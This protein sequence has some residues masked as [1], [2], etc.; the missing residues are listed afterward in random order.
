MNKVVR[1][2][3]RIGVGVLGGIVLLAGLIAIPYPG[4]GWLI[5]FAGLAILATEFDWAQRLLD[6]VRGKYDEWQAWLRRQKRSTRTLF[7]IMTCIM[8]IVTIWILN[9]YG[10]IDTW[11]NL[12][13][14]WLHSP[15]PIFN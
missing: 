6:S 3:K 15:L 2:A 14:D 12:G 5:V 13:L 7:Y 10:L 4:P 11:L 1:H 9:G 8:V